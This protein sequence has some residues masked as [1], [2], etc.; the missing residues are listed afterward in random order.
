VP[1]TLFRH[2]AATALAGLLAGAALGTLLGRA[3]P[4]PAAAASHYDL[5]AR[6][7][8]RVPGL[9]VVHPNGPEGLSWGLYLTTTDRPRQELL[10][11]VR[12]RPDDP[13][14]RGTVY[15]WRVVEGVERIDP[16]D[17]EVEGSP[18]LLLWGDP[19]LIRRIREA[20]R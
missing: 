7:S 15:C 5:A 8:A 16:D 1:A 14:W 4:P 11:L 6:V 10:A 19:D 18:G 3:H 2:P 12:D 13:R 20:M 17:V 9:R